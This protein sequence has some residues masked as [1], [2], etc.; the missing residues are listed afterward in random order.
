MTTKHAA[1]ADLLDQVA[2]HI[3]ATEGARA[4]EKT[5]ARQAKASEAVS[6]FEAVSGE[7]LSPEL[8]SKLA[9]LDEDVLAHLTR[10]AKITGG[11]PD[12]LGG[13]ADDNDSTTKVAYVD[14]IV[15]FAMG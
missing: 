1:L 3:D 15:A 10:T 5:A 13:P 4:R 8:R 9:G 14:P 6:A 2:A 12:S 7:T 11:S